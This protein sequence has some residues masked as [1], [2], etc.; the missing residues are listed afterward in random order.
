VVVSYNIFLVRLFCLP[1]LAAPRGNCPPLPLLVT[2]L[3]RGVTDDDALLSTISCDHVEQ[4]QRM[5]KWHR[6]RL[7]RL[8]PSWLSV[9]RFFRPIGLVLYSIP[10][11]NIACRG[12]RFF[13]LGRN[14]ENFWTVYAC[15]HRFMSFISKCW[16]SVLDKWLKVRVV[17]VTEKNTFWHPWVEPMG[18]VLLIFV[19]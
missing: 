6:C 2:P 18:R 14:S 12:L 7:N 19:C 5:A 9:P 13:G 10:R 17:L 1:W 3:I 11:Q 8:F 4:A 15:A 16:K